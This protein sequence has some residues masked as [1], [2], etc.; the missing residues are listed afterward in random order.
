MNSSEM[1][2]TI[3]ADALVAVDTSKNRVEC[4]GLYMIGK[5]RIV[6]VIRRLNGTGLVEVDDYPEHAEEVSFLDD[7]RI[8]VAGS[9]Q[10]PVLGAVHS[11]MTMVRPSARFPRPRR[12]LSDDVAVI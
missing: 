3:P 1:A 5:S 8:I 7:G 4:I 2:P 11:F 6:R 9:N 10:V 12:P